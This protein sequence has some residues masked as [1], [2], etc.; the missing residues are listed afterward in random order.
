M[1]YRRRKGKGAE[2]LP[3][4][5]AVVNPKRK[6]SRYPF[7]DICGGLVAYK[8]V[9]VLY[10]AFGVPEEEWLELMEF[11]A[12]ATV[13]DVMRL[14]DENRIIVK[15]GLKRLGR[16]SNIGLR[17]LIE[18]NN[19]SADRITAY[20][21]GFVIGPC[22]NAGGRLMTAKLALSLLLCRDEEE[23]DRM[24]AELKELND[25]RKD[26]TQEGIDQ[27]S[28]LVEERCQKDLV[29]V[30]FLPDCHESLAGIVG[31]ASQGAV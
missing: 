5:D 12:I 24:A 31:R 26:M 13:G 6:D 11:A 3:P 19:L 23:A 15:E 2:L 14:Q 17:K 28:A 25:R 7:R 16:T 9:Q 30:V 10:E 8:L 27:A 20:H 29:L 1:I 18:K 4:A 21:I 22:L